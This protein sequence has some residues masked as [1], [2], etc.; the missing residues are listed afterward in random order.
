MARQLRLK[1][2]SE[3]L[4]SLNEF[5]RGASNSLAA[6]AVE[7]WPDWIGG[8]LAIVGPQGSG[9][10]HLARAWAAATGAIVFER[11]PGDISQPPTQPVLIEDIDQGIADETLFHLIN[12]AGRSGGALLLT[13]RSRPAAWITDLPDLRSR[14]NA[15]PVVE[16]EAPDDTVLEGVLRKFFRD[17]N[18]RPPEGVY[19]YLLSRMNRSIPEAQEIVRRLD[20]AGD[21]G[22]RPVTRVLARQILEENQLLDL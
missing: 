5:A 12:V 15:M 1:L 3:R 8:C 17:R 18:I 13:A 22:F 14:L 7:S 10:S 20:E 21:D 19:P 11:N 6:A 16:I 2:Q 4:A 9:K